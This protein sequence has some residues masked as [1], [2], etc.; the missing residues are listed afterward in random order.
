MTGHHVGI[1]ID[2]VDRINDRDPVPVAEN[3][4]NIAAITFGAIGNEDLVIGNRYSARAVIIFRNCAPKKF[5]TLG[6]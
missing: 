6:P 2:G 3:I 5:I 4:Q 1:Y